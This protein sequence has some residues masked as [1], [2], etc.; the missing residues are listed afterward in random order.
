MFIGAAP[1]ASHSLANMPTFLSSSEVLLIFCDIITV[2]LVFQQYT[3][4]GWPSLLVLGSA[5]TYCGAIAACHMMTFPGV[6]GAEGLLAAGPQSS[7]WIYLFWH[8]SFPLL[9][10]AYAIV[11][12]RELRGADAMARTPAAVSYAGRR[13]LLCVLAAVGVAASQA[14][15]SI[16]WKDQLPRLI[17]HG[18]FL[19]LMKGLA[20]IS[21][22]A[23][24]LAIG[25]L[26]RGGGVTVLR[27]WLIVTMGVW[28]LDLLMTNTISGGRYDLGSGLI[29]S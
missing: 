7:V 21:S 16:H 12:Q 20:L 23:C 25:A 27:L 4:F 22:G 26:L 11:S 1:F 2:A 14:A 17:L 19:P 10:L 29:A 6:F 5:Y 8:A 18:R 28:M 13:I 9:L 3:F 24:L 15:L